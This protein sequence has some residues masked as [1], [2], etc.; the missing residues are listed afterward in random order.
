M[1]Q[2]NYFILV[3]PSKFADGE[4]AHCYWISVVWNPRFSAVDGKHP[5]NVTVARIS[6]QVFI[7]YLKN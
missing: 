4:W 1:E 2:E 7:F 3:L 5:F 6:F